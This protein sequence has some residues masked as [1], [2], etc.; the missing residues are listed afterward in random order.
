MLTEESLYHLHRALNAAWSI[1]KP[2]ALL[3]VLMPIVILTSHLRSPNQYVGSTDLI[4]H[5]VN[6]TGIPSIDKALQSNTFSVYRRKGL[7]EQVKNIDKLRE[8]AI[9]AGIID[10]DSNQQV[11]YMTLRNIQEKWLDVHFIDESYLTLKFRFTDR[12]KNDAFMKLFTEWTKESILATKLNMGKKKQISVQANLKQLRLDRQDIANKIRLLEEKNQE[13]S[14]A[15]YS[16]DSFADLKKAM[17]EQE[18][19]LFVE[20]HTQEAMKPRILHLLGNLKT[21][22]QNTNL[23]QPDDIT[24]LEA[25]LARLQ[26]K[27][28]PHHS[29]IRTLKQ[30]IARIK[31]NQKTKNE[32]EENRHIREKMETSRQKRDLNTIAKAFHRYNR[33]LSKE[34]KRQIEAWIAKEDKVIAQE[35]RLRKL[36]QSLPFLEQLEK[37]RVEEKRIIENIEYIERGLTTEKRNAQILENLS[38]HLIEITDVQ[39]AHIATPKRP[40]LYLIVGLFAAMITASGLTLLYL[41]LESSIQYKREIRE[42]LGEDQNTEVLYFTKPPSSEK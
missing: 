19:E 27:Y 11:Q 3:I 10:K 31:A 22:S 37:L 15:L 38:N 36:K 28:T 25:Q 8:L 2:I 33:D 6:G 39:P 5:K 16:F 29:K 26:Q 23:S 35:V 41:F 20:R 32:Q 21:S 14:K 9:A 34:Q 17:H 24:S 40:V 42:I 13:K 12:N 18:D 4:L 7:V 30:R 1:R